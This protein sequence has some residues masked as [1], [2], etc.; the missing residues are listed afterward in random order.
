MFLALS[1]P[2]WPTGVAAHELPFRLLALAPRATIAARDGLAWLDAR[3][4]DVDDLAHRALVVA[5]ELGITGVH[6]AASHV[7]A[8]AS[9]AARYV[10]TSSLIIPRGSERRFLASLPLVVLAPPPRLASLFTSVGLE[11][12]SDL[13]ALDR[14]SVEVRFGRDGLTCWKLSRADDSRLIFR[15]QPRTLPNASIDWTEFSTTDIEQ[16]VFV[17]HSM[18]G[19]ICN[20]LAHD[21]LGARSITITLALEGGKTLLQH[22]GSAR[23]SFDRKLWL[24]LVRRALERITLPDRVAGIAIDVDATGP[25]PIRQGDLFDLGFASAQ[26]AEAAVAHVIDMQPDAVA[27][28]T[29]TQHVL[30]ERRTRWKAELAPDLDEMR[31]GS[32]TDGPSAVSRQPPGAGLRL[33]AYGHLVLRLLPTPREI[34]VSAEIQRGFPTPRRYVDNGLAVPLS[35]SLGPQCMAGNDFD[36]PIAREYYQGV[37]TDGSVVLMFREPRPERWYLAGVWD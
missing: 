11:H 22:V 15:A 29:R 14:E 25:P 28:A 19:T 18:L 36:A 37:R 4:L 9:I 27:V 17:M 3:G 23:P 24:R 13:A 6:A 31:K 34:D 7:P 10:A 1:I 2:D 5:S 21:G 35:H 20:A 33:M 26:A 30:P 32:T 12:C 16:L 8:V